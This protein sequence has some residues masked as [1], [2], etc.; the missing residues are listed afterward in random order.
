[1][2]RLEASLHLKTIETLIQQIKKDPILNAL[3]EQDLL[4]KLLS[5]TEC[6]VHDCVD[7]NEQ[8]YHENR[9]L[10]EKLDHLENEIDYQWRYNDTRDSRY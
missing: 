8:F 10:A 3:V 2:N 1:M 9:R 7:S 5:E 4:K 6:L